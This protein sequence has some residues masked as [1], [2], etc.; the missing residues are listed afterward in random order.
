MSEVG[1]PDLGSAASETRVLGGLGSELRSLARV[2]RH[3]RSQTYMRCPD[4]RQSMMRWH[5]GFGPGV[6]LLPRPREGGL[7]RL[8]LRG[9]RIFSSDAWSVEHQKR[10]RACRHG[11]P[12]VLAP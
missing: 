7:P 4:S 12:Q 1:K 5:T 3:R 8:C 10:A 9:V 6:R 2:Y 11:A